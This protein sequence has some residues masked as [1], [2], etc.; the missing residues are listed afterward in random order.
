MRVNDNFA[1]SQLKHDGDM[2]YDDEVSLFLIQVKS[3]SDFGA[4][5]NNDPTEFYRQHVRDILGDETDVRAVVVRA[6]AEIPAN[7]QH[8]SHIV[9]TQTGNSA[10]VTAIQYKYEK[11][12]VG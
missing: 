11:D 9:G 2:L 5:L 3:D 10:T 1:F 4:L 12:M 8:T 6:N 7:P